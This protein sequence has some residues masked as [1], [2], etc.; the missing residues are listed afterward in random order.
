MVAFRFGKLWTEALWLGGVGGGEAEG[1]R[2]ESEGRS[3][4]WKYDEAVTG[5]TP[6]LRGRL[7]LASEQATGATAGPLADYPSKRGRYGFGD[8]RGPQK[9]SVY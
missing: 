9:K 5:G 7:R 4:K 6:L 1:G 3:G 8:G 2:P